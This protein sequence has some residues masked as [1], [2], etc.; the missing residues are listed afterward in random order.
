MDLWE[1]G[2]THSRNR[3]RKSEALMF[4]CVKS[5]YLLSRKDVGRNHSR[6]P[7]AG[8][9]CFAFRF[10]TLCFLKVKAVRHLAHNSVSP[11]RDP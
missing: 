2:S 9:F 1:V 10:C 5:Y 6:V 7:E 11:V 3:S 4:N 8:P